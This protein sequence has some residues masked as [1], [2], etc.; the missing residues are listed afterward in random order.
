M[1]RFSIRKTDGVRRA[2]TSWVRMKQRCQNPNHGARQY[3][4]D[5][6]PPV[7]VC[8][9]WQRFKLFLKDLGERPAGA[10]LGRIL[11]IGDYK[12]GNAFWQTKSEQASERM[13]KTA[14][15]AAHDRRALPK[16]IRWRWRT[17]KTHWRKAA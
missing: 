14:M 11:D 17:G 16:H 1:K 4:G 8:K 13:G 10:S 15:R 3:Y 2:H 6:N 12:P 5:A 9:R 7:R